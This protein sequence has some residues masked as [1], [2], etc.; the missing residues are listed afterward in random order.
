MNEYLKAGGSKALEC[1]N[2]YFSTTTKSDEVNT[3]SILL[4]ILII[5]LSFK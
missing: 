2:D 3:I 5:F 4:F 1:Y